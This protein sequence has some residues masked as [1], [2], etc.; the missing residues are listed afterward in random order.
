MG[1]TLKQES[2]ISDIEKL[3]TEENDPRQR[4]VLIILNSINSSLNESA[5]L[6]RDVAVKLDHHILKTVERNLKN[7]ALVNKG[8]G[9][10]IVAAWVL[11]IIQL[12]AVFIFLQVRQEL[13]DLHKYT[14]FNKS[15]NLA[16][17]KEINKLNLEILKSK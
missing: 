12:V 3:I 9:A 11:G 5:H 15:V 14:E 2:R 10:W 17:E 6:T 4:A 8:R 13:S 1:T 7:D 16:Q